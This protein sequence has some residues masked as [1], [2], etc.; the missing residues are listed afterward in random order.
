MVATGR[1][2]LT[3]DAFAGGA[4]S[5]VTLTLA[6]PPPPQLTVQTK[7]VP[8]PLQEEKEK[9]AST[10]K[11]SRALLRFMWHPTPGSSAFAMLG[12]ENAKDNQF[13]CSARERRTGRQKEM[14]CSTAKC[15]GLT[16]M[17]RFF[18]LSRGGE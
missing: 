2:K 1:L 8:G 10:S 7:C 16:G 5:S 13:E 3:K 11:K 4:S 15:P 14:A 6:L 17:R 18:S 9:V 12:K